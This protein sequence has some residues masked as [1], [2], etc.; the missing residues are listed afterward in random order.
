MA[1]AVAVMGRR[2]LPVLEDVGDE[3]LDVLPTDVGG[4]RRHAL[5]SEEA[6]E[7][8][9]RG[10]VCRDR[11]RADPLGA[12]MAAPAGQEFAE[13]AGDRRMGRVGRGCSHRSR[14]GCES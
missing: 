1:A 13:F 10:R 14:S 7:L 6:R 5:T 4:R 9:D 3:R 12:E 2:G 8:S 11:G